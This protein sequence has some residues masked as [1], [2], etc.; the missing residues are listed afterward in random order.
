[1]LKILF[2]FSLVSFA[3]DEVMLTAGEQEVLSQIL[4][5]TASTHRPPR[6][7]TLRLDGI[8]YETPQSW[9]VWLNGRAYRPQ[10]PC[11]YGQILEVTPQKVQLEIQAGQRHVVL[12]FNQEVSLIP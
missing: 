9:V 11:E 12:Q 5:Q 4:S 6:Q 3:E 10:E 2:W 1:M 7:S 8:L